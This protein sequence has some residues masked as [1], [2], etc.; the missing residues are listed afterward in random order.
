MVGG[1][2]LGPWELELGVLMMVVRVRV[3]MEVRTAVQ[4]RMA[5]GSWE[6]GLQVWVALKVRAG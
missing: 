5:V 3:V 2:E 6:L 1:A 4:V